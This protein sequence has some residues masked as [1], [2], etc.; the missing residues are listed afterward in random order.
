MGSNNKELAVLIQ[1]IKISLYVPHESQKLEMSLHFLVIF[2][3]SMCFLH[4][5]G[6]DNNFGRN[7]VEMIS[8]LFPPRHY[9]STIY[10]GICNLMYKLR[11]LQY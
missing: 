7:V 2:T 6:S 9:Y 11:P 8:M 3:A 10:M 5:T 4:G 1:G